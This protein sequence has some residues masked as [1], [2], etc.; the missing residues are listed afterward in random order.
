MVRLLCC[1]LAVAAC[2]S[3]PP[4]S[5][6]ARPNQV[7]F[8]VAGGPL[9]PGAGP[10]GPIYANAT[11]DAKVTAPA[12]C[13]GHAVGERMAAGEAIIGCFRRWDGESPR[14]QVDRYATS[15]EGR[16]L[17]RVII[18]APE[19]L[20][21]LAAIQADLARL[22][23]PRRLSAA[24]G[25][26]L[27]A[28]VPA[29]AW[30]GY[31]IHGDETSGADAA[32]AFGYHL[33]AATDADT[34]ALLRK[35][36][37]VIDP[38]MNPDGRA[39]FL[40]QV[41][42]S[43]SAVPSLD[44]D[45]MSRGHWPWGR[46]NHYLFDMNRDWFLGVAPETRGRWQALAALPP[47][48][49]VDV[50]EMGAQESFLSYPYNDPVNPNF[51][52][53]VRSWQ[54]VFTGDLARAFDGFGWAYYTREWADG[55]YPGYSDAWAGLRGAVGVLYEQARNDGQ[56]VRQATG[57]V[58]TYRDA[59]QHQAIASL[60]NLLTFGRNRDALLRDY[61]AFR[62]ASVAPPGPRRAFALVPGRA[63][64]RERRLLGA[65]LRQG[66][67]VYRVDA[68]FAP[69]GAVGALGQAAPASLHR[70]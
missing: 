53:N 15:H 8:D 38:V 46:G 51:A 14:V 20:A 39:R 30:F 7:D 5:S 33:A 13:L 64:D 52:A 70:G 45:S 28:R 37:V 4:A 47:Q 68:D 57:D 62:R 55:W 59:V 17:V 3:A 66:I 49:L 54:A 1:S 65:L 26:A 18:T 63:P 9:A 22:A 27:L 41:A 40:S 6:P 32:V 43:A 48:L 10:A 25:Q 11:Y 42:Q 12:T 23:D 19:N 2:S 16:E 56:A 24:D 21:R 31:S 61:L 35:V 29:V 67:E 34:E 36:I 60:S 58:R 69:R 44:Q 50:H